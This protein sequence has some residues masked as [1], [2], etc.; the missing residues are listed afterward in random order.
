MAFTDNFPKQRRLIKLLQSDWF[1]EGVDH[2]P[3][4]V[5]PMEPRKGIADGYCK[6]ENRIYLN[7]IE[8]EIET[9]MIEIPVNYVPLLSQ[10][11]DENDNDPSD[12][13]KHI[14]LEWGRVAIEE[15]LHE[16]EHKC[17]KSEMIS[18]EARALHSSYSKQFYPTE[19][20]DVEFFQA[21]VMQAGYFGLSSRELTCSLAGQ[22]VSNNQM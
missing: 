12:P 1:K 17:V 4:C 3:A 19:R 14:E 10:T 21:I 5:V 13:M 18:S 16:F 8:D 7:K 11:T 2:Y 15:V 22:P 9:P 6:S 20:H